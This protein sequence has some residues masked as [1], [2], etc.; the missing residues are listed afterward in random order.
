[1]GEIYSA[2]SGR[3]PITNILTKVVSNP[4]KKCS[5][6]TA[7]DI[8]SLTQGRDSDINPK[9]KVMSSTQGVYYDISGMTSIMLEYTITVLN[10]VIDIE[11]STL[12]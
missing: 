11:L 9:V 4:R 8:Q 6:D 7:K 12:Y 1:M 2:T 10:G 3:Y 5:H